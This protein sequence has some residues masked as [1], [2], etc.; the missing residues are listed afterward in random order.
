M[1]SSPAHCGRPTRACVARIATRSRNAGG[2]WRYI[3]RH[4]PANREVLLQLLGLLVTTIV[5][6]TLGSQLGPENDKDT[7]NE[8][9]PDRV[10]VPV[11][12]GPIETPPVSLNAPPIV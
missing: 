12:L 2:V 11:P 10:N 7:L 5:M 3:S 1:R 8:Q 9:P 4:M 6:M